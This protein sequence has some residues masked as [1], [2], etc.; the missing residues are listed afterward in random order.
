MAFIASKTCI[1]TNPSARGNRARF[2]L[3]RREEWCQMGVIMETSGPGDAE[4]L[5]SEAIQNGFTTVIAAGGDGTVYEVLNGLIS[6]NINYDE[7]RLGV[8]PL[9]TVNVFAK[10][11]GLSMNIA[12]C[13]EVLY[14]GVSR[15]IDLPIACF[16]KGNREKRRYFV[17]LGG[18]GLDA[19]A[20]Q[21]VNLKMKKQ[22]GPIAYV[23]AGLKVLG[24]SLPP[25]QCHTAEGMQAE[26]KLVLLGNGAYYGGRFRVFPD[27]RLDD[28]C[29]HAL[30]FQDVKYFQLPWR[31]IGLFLNKLHRQSGVTYL[32]STSLELKSEGQAYF[33]LEGEVVGQLPA[34]FQMSSKKL[35]VIVPD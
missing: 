29:I 30:V 32:K 28:G 20:I 31:A 33:E 27:A 8:L 17:Q 15:N 21:E 24:K 5:T 22:L 11:L 9:G 35:Q 19:F 23:L 13:K 14:K 4:K 16:K 25:I 7:F 3:E 6:S 12:R 26:G 34:N 1:I 10:E 2:F 18:A